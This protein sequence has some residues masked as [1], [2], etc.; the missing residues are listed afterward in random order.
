MTHY[1]GNLPRL[2]TYNVFVYFTSLFTDAGFSRCRAAAAW[3]A[4]VW[5]APARTRPSLSKAL[6]W[7]LVFAV[8]HSGPRTKKAALIVSDYGKSLPFSSK[9]LKRKRTRR[10]TCRQCHLILLHNV[11]I[12]RYT[13]TLVARLQKRN[14]NQRARCT[15]LH[16]SCTLRISHRIKVRAW[17]DRWTARK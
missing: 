6:T 3:R 16:L 10:R 4:Q 8:E 1:L 7:K 12:V 14:I 17:N 2:L 13:Y 9:R 5:G 11:L 15:I